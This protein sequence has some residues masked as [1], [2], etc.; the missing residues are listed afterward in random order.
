MRRR[1]QAVAQPVEGAQ[2]AAAGLQAGRRA[3]REGGRQVCTAGLVN[4]Q[5]ARL[6]C[7]VFS[8]AATSGALKWAREAQ[9][10]P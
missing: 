7:A 9:Y 10:P 2:Q 5:V 8:S 4:G 1:Q 3:G 6:Q